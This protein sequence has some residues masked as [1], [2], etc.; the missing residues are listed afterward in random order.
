MTRKARLIALTNDAFGLSASNFHFP[1]YKW[2]AVSERTQQIVSSIKNSTWEL[3]IR[4]VQQLKGIQ[5]EEGYLSLEERLRGL[6]KGYSWKIEY[7]QC[8]FEDEED[9]HLLE[10]ERDTIHQSFSTEDTYQD[11]ILNRIRDIWE[12]CQKYYLDYPEI[13]IKNFRPSLLSLE[14]IDGNE[15]LTSN[16]DTLINIRSRLWSNK[17]PL[18]KLMYE[19]V[20][21]TESK[22]GTWEYSPYKEV[23]K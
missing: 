2:M 9:I 8:L 23:S 13:E 21:K 18:S 3:T 15:E 19:L 11:Y 14:R 16:I 4:N 12:T 20:W 22:R 17:N 1:I 5:P 6:P 7:A 10:F